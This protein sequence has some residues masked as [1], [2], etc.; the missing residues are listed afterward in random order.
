MGNG[1]SMTA[2]EPAAVSA[3]L[4]AEFDPEQTGLLSVDD[5]TMLAMR[6]VSPLNPSNPRTVLVP[7]RC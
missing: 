4:F 1:I 3:S 7:R 2:P 6:Y 5:L